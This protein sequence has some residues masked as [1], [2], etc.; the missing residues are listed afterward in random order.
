MRVV[1][2]LL[3]RDEADLV[4]EMARYHLARGV[5]LVLVTDHRSTDGTSEILEQLGTTARV[6][7]ARGV[8][9]LRQSDWVTRMSRLAASEHGADWVIPSDAD[10]FWWP[11][12][13]SLHGSWTPS[14]PRFGACEALA[15]FVPRPEDGQ[16]FFERMT[17]RRPPSPDLRIRT[18]RRSRSSIG[19]RPTWWSP[20][21]PRRPR[22]GAATDARMAPLRDPPL[23]A[24]DAA[25]ARRKF[26]V[27]REAGRRSPG[28]SVPQHTE[29]AVVAMDAEGDGSYYERSWF[30]MMSWQD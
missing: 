11:R 28:T 30:A 29:A 27:A 5:D 13:G 19:E 25:Q 20:G 12:D 14:R 3:V 18:T 4:E 10:E 6:G 8:G 16:P 26:R 2:T 9:G 1:M 22:P 21:Q 7:A 15:D 17:L 24:P 23:P